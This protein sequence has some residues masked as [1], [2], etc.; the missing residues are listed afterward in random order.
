MMQREVYK[1]FWWNA[2]EKEIDA[3]WT[4]R[5]MEQK[6]WLLSL[7]YKDKQE[8]IGKIK[9]DCGQIVKLYIKVWILSFKLWLGF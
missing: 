6:G 1:E 4:I 2:K 7:I 5:E 8:F 9:T 3:P